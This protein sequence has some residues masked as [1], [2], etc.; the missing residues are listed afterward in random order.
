MSIPEK[1]CEKCGARVAWVGIWTNLVL[2]SLKMIVGVT[3]GSKALMADGL[4]S[5]SNIITASAILVSQKF[6]RKE[7]NEEFPYGYGKVEFLA[8]GAITILITTAAIILITVSIRHLL[9][10]PQS[11]SPR[12]TAVMMALISIGTNEMLFRYMRCVGTHAN[13]QTIMASAWANRADCFSSLAVIIGVLGSK[14]GL[15]H[16]DPVAALFVVAVIIKVSVGIL[17]NSVKALMDSSANNI[18]GEEIEA[19][20]EEME[21]VKG[22]SG[23]KT[24]LVGHKVWAELDIL[25]DSNC[26]VQDG[27][28]IALR[29]KEALLTKIRDLERVLINFSPIG[30]D[31]Y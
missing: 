4:H 16:M 8:A 9:H 12:Y 23:L 31:G 11:S 26:S 28:S 30:E 7:A 1:S 2:A 29:V 15:N 6:G 21:E 5:T 19:I 24:R 14:M 22:V 13:S 3:S 18:Y 25:V 10:A 17:K 27:Q 20:V